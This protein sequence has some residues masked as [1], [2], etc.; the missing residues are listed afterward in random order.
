MDAVKKWNSNPVIRLP[1]HVRP[2]PRWY[3]GD[4]RLRRHAR[5]SSLWWMQFSALLRLDISVLVQAGNSKQAV[6]WL[7]ESAKRR[8]TNGDQAVRW[9]SFLQVEGSERR[10]L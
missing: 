3:C 4:T 9:P 6:Q 2:L 5:F 7:E 1:E 10:V 8:M